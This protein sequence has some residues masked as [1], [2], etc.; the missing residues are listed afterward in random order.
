[1]LFPPLAANPEPFAR[2]LSEKLMT[3]AKGSELNYHER[4]LIADLVESQR[5]NELRLNELVQTL[6]DS[7]VFRN[8]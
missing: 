1:M 2:C 4:C 8:R 6:I 3:Y 7:P 5:E